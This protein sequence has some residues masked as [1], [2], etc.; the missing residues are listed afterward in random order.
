M[1]L[2]VQVPVADTTPGIVAGTQV[3]S[4]P[5]VPEAAHGEGFGSF[6]PTS[7]EA[8]HG[9]Q[10]VAL[11]ELSIQARV[12]REGEGLQEERPFLLDPHFHPRVWAPFSPPS[13]EETEAQNRNHP[14]RSN[15]TVG[16][17]ELEFKFPSLQLTPTMQNLLDRP[18]PF[19]PW[20][21]R[22][23]AATEGG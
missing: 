19:F 10:G 18:S 15:P 2:H 7:P 4:Y 21:P 6:L 17:G 3:V 16:A 23:Q 5:Q 1:Q 20:A 14:P 9:F 12:G 11:T 13:D 8:E 22:S